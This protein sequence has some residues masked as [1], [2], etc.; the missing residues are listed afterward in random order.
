VWRDGG[1]PGDPLWLIFLPPD[2]AMA[3]LPRPRVALCAGSWVEMEFDTESGFEMLPAG[4]P[5]ADGAA[6]ANASAPP[7]DPRAEVSL[8]YL[9]RWVLKAVSLWH[10]P[11]CVLSL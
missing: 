7:P 1:Q 9:R 4:A 2:H 10:M 5:G 8:S 3:H 11:S 6:A